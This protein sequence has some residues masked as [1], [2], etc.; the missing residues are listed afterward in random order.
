[1]TS[2]IKE[3]AEKIKGVAKSLERQ[4]IFVSA[5]IVLVAGASFGLGALS[6]KNSGE[7]I[8][9]KQTVSVF[10]SLKNS[11]NTVNSKQNLTEGKFVGSKNSDKYHYPWCS[12][13]QRIKE[14]NKIWFAGKEEAEAQG[15]APAGNCKGL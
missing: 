10:D 11:E 9:I 14:E 1:M 2:S 15:Y 12:G 13:A 3:V 5:L 4:D 8:E 7:D 6:T